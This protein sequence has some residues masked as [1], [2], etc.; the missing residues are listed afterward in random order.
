MIAHAIM[1]RTEVDCRMGVVQAFDFT[2]AL[3]FEH[4]VW[5]R[6]PGNL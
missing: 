1:A 2:I 5:W 4:V 6:N 3:I